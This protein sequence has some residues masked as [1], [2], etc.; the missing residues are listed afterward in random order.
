[1][2]AKKKS[3]PKAAASAAKKS[4][5]NKPP[6]PL[7]VCA[8]GQVSKAAKS[9]LNR[10]SEAAQ[11]LFRHNTGKPQSAPT[12]SPRPGPRPQPQPQPPPRPQ[13]AP[14]PSPAPN[15]PPTLY[16]GT[17][18]AEGTV[19]KNRAAYTT[20]PLTNSA[21]DRSA[22]NYD[23]VINQFGVANNA[24]Y[25]KQGSGETLKTYCNIFAWDVTRAMGAEI[26][27]WVDGKGNAVAPGQGSEMN[28]N[29]TVNWLSK[30]GT[31]NGWRKVGADEAQQMANAGHPAIAIWQNPSGASGHIAVVRPGEVTAKGPT[32]AQ[33]GWA[34][35]NKTDTQTGFGKNKTLDYWVHD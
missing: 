24:R 10:L 17:T 11:S 9:L 22:G 16:D 32:I 20:P 23:Q 4:A 31:E 15:K 12:P 3:S 27:H 18:P 28:V 14:T 33:A 1:V 21:N 13:T 7:H 8:A 19:V 2:P 29:S 35:Y 26:P 34:N 25:L 6:G 5:P 30:H